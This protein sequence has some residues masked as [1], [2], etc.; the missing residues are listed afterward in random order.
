MATTALGKVSL[1]MG[2]DYSA[3]TTYP[4][5]TVVRGVNGDSYVSTQSNVSGV[6]PGVT[7]GWENY[8]QLLS[9]DGQDGSSIASITLTSSVGNVDTYTITL[10]NGDTSTFTVT[11]GTGVPDG[12]TQGQV[13]TVGANST[14][15]W[16]DP[17][18]GVESVTVQQI[19]DSGTE[20]GGVTVDGVQTSLYAPTP[21]SIIDDT[22]GSGATTKV[23]SASKTASELAGKSTV[24][25]TANLTSGTQIAAVRIDNAA[26]PTRLYAPNPTSIIDDTAGSGA[27]AKVWSANKSY[28][29]LSGKQNA[30]ASAGTAGQVLGLNSSLQPVW[31]NAGGGGGSDVSV[32]QIVSTGTKIAT[33]TVDGSG[34][35]LYAPNSG[36]STVS[37]TQVVSTGTKIAT[38]TVDGTGTDLYAPS[39]GGGGSEIDDTAGTGVTNKTW[40]A[41]KLVDEFDDKQ[42]A[43]AV[44]GTSGQLLSL[45]S[46]G[47]PVWI[48]NTSIYRNVTAGVQIAAISVVGNSG[49][50]VQLYAPICT[51]VTD[52]DTSSSLTLTP[53]PTTYNFGESASLTLVVTAT[54]QYHFMFSCPSGAATVLSITGITGTT[55]DTTLEAGAT[56]EVDVWAGIAYYKKIE[57]TAV[58]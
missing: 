23:W 52:A 48:N 51:V 56:Y 24:S 28:T 12:G 7:S 1:T 16:A 47:D 22:A 55:G 15:I 14:R 33:I 17:T 8:W 11:N 20:I 58:T 27:T 30:P 53:C 19:L 31:T 26:N 46:N 38:I 25:L 49:N 9:T 13:L 10:T 45:D 5:L 18:G 41:N 54:T 21:T 42:D 36:G 32:T 37:V 57:V 6:S 3:T 43:P 39:G 50:A 29:E 35:D 34:T 4:I 2:G 44:A 40:S